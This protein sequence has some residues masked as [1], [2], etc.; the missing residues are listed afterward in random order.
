MMPD[1]REGFGEGELMFYM[2]TYLK[3]E[4]KKRQGKTSI[5]HFFAL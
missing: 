4:G 1:W 3:L 5:F 2:R